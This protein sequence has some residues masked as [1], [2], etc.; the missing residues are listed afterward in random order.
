[1]KCVSVLAYRVIRLCLRRLIDI[2]VIMLG[3]RLTESDRQRLL[4]VFAVWDNAML[5]EV[6]W[7][8]E[9]MIR[10]RRKCLTRRNEG[11]SSRR[12]YVI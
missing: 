3:S 6:V 11:G 1:M 9:K 5:M 7:L 10:D 2:G 12:S 4:E 8:I